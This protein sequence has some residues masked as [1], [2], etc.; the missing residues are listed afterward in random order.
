MQTG[1]GRICRRDR[2][3]GRS[4]RKFCHND[5]KNRLTN[6]IKSSPC[7]RQSHTRKNKEPSTDE[8]RHARIRNASRGHQNGPAGQNAR[9]PCR[10]VPYPCLR[11]RTTPSDARP[12]TRHLPHTSRLR[13]QHHARRTRPLRCHHQGTHRHARGAHHRTSRHRTCPWRHHDQHVR[14]HG[15][16]LRPNP[17]RAR[18]GRPPHARRPQP[19]ARGDEPPAHRTPRDLPLRPHTT[20]PRKPH[21][22]ERARRAHP[23]DGQHGHRR[24]PLGSRV[25]TS[26]HTLGRRHR[27]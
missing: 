8:N 2:I 13:P 11:D 18:R 1:A 12:S 9:K 5:R 16:L 23:G 15:R 22:R 21:G 3:S 10:R 17:C 24:P 27:E 4:D 6:R 19:L 25:H 7:H 26:R 14:S 20:E